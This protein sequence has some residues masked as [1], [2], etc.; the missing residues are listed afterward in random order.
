MIH[1]HKMHA[2]II[3]LN[4]LQV[5]FTSTLKYKTRQI[6]LYRKLVMKNK[7]KFTNS[8]IYGDNLRDNMLGF[9]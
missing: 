2:R 6:S 1:G 4:P 5:H 9:I 8:E 3:S 7:F